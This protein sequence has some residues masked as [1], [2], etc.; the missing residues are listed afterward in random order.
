MPED[1]LTQGLIGEVFVSQ[2]IDSWL[3]NLAEHAIFIFHSH[4]D[5]KTYLNNI[6]VYYV[7]ASESG[8]LAYGIVGNLS[9]SY[10]SNSIAWHHSNE[11]Y[12]RATIGSVTSRVLELPNNWGL[13][14]LANFTFK[15]QGVNL[16]TPNS[17]LA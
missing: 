14:K 15:M 9:L 2:L 8:S 10:G 4:Q 17:G 13:Q 11:I 7:F 16:I 12:Q 5:Q 3:K 1:G 6:P